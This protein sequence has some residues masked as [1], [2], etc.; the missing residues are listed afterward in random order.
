MISEE[1]IERIAVKVAELLN[2]P[3]SK[4]L[5]LKEAAEFMKI[6]AQ[7][8]S[9]PA[10]FSRFSSI[11]YYQKPLVAYK[12]G[13]ERIYLAEDLLKFMHENGRRN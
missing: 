6:K 8:K 1:D 9:L 11:K 2:K 3:Q 13:K 10:V 12:I 7:E 5:S 4:T